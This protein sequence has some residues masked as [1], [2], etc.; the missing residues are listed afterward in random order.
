MSRV[1]RVPIELPQGVEV[2][3]EGEKILVSGPKGKLELIIDSPNIQVEIGKTRVL[4]KRLDEDLG[5]GAMHGLYRALLANMVKGVTVG[6]EKNLELTGVG[7]R[8]VKQGNKLILQLGHSHPIEIDPPPG[9]EINVE[10]TNKIKVLGIDRRM[11]GQV[12]QN[13]KYYRPIE[14]YK[15]K[16]V[17]YQGD[18]VRRKVGK[19]AKTAA[20]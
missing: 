14:P 8:A 18:F 12:A 19:A 10:G 15:G 5:T 17:N 1:G 20:A 11:V 4:V 3:G 7:Y 13:I 16:G 2:K 6:F 9:I